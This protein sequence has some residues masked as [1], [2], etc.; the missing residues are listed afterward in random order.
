MGSTAA[1]IEGLERKARVFH[2]CGN[3]IFE[4]FDNFYWKEI[5][6]KNIHKNIY[7]YKI[8]KKGNFIRFGNEKDTL[9]TLKV[10]F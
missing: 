3:D 1:V 7:E 2:I 6:I 8:Q 9:S 4:K 5:K 10:N